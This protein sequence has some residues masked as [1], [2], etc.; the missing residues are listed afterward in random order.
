MQKG[1][2][3]IVTQPTTVLD[4]AAPF[5]RGETAE[6][7]V[8]TR[9]ESARREKEARKASRSTRPRRERRKLDGVSSMRVKTPEQTLARLRRA[10]PRRKTI[11][12]RERLAKRIREL[13]AALERLA[14]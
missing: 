7:L 12:A 4:K 9:T 10:L 6:K 2:R 8:A 14:E 11:A 13:E 3:R 5:W 1:T